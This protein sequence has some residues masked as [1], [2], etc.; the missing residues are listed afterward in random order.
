MPDEEM[1]SFEELEALLNQHNFDMPEVG[2]IRK[3]LIVSISNQGIIVDLGLKRDGL[4][5]TADLNKLEPEER[6]ELKL[7]ED[8]FVYVQQTDQPDS[9]IV[10]IYLAKLN[11]D[12]IDAETLLENGNVIEGEIAGYNKGGAIVEFGR[13]RGFIP[14]SHLVDFNPGMA[15]RKRQQKLAKLR[16]TKIPLKVIEVDRRRKRLV[17][18]QREAQREWEEAKRVELLQELKEGD[19]R[20]GRVSGLRDFGVFVDLGGADGLIHISELAW[21]RVD[22]PREVL[23]V[24]DEIQV[25]VMRLDPSHERISL[26]RK[27]LLGNPWDTVE[28]RY[29]INQL[30]EG[31]VT[32][33]VDYGA[34]AEIEPG[35]EGLLHVSQLSRSSV[36]SPGEVVQVGETHLL[37]VV[38]I[39][40]RRQRIGLSLKA[41]TATEQIEWMAHRDSGMAASAP[42]AGWVSDDEDEADDFESSDFADEEVEGEDEA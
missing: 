7:D 37:R 33:L 27:K 5:P 20:T 3:G 17:L 22:H 11:Q 13:I 19:I 12:W 34:F 14:L 39:D 1:T 24:G 30:V 38:S 28:Q 41:V 35:V 6:A 4:V 42:A 25:Y 32:R 23:K 16:G 36:E 21:H 26:S 29:H 2:D 10:S 8:V 9:L 31:K 18:S 15:D 40:P